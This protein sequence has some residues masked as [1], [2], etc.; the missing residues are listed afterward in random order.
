MNILHIKRLTKLFIYG[1]ELGA[2]PTVQ[3]RRY[4]I[5]KKFKN[6]KKT[7]ERENMV[8]IWE[9]FRKFVDRCPVLIA[10][11]LLKKKKITAWIQTISN[12]I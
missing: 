8:L 2:L 12:N 9:V 11:I 10:D 1:L 7:E 3:K 5:N 6:N 4:L